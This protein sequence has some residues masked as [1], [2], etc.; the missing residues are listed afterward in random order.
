MT[1]TLKGDPMAQSKADPTR[2]QLP[3]E[4]RVPPPANGITFQYHGPKD[5]GRAESLYRSALTKPDLDYCAQL[6]FSALVANPEHEAAFEAIL[7]RLPA[8]AAR[9]RKMVVRI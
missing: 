5:V 8:F 4:G 1:S 7:A 6:L 3:A 2:P 9:G